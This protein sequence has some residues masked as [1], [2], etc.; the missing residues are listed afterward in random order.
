M[1]HCNN[2]TAPALYTTVAVIIIII[3]IVIIVVNSVTSKRQD[4]LLFI[5]VKQTAGG[6]DVTLTRVNRCFHRVSSIVSM[7]ACEF[8]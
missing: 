1:L 5:S 2:G 7:L 3:I 4:H 8:S 6:C